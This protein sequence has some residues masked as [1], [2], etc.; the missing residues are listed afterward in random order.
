MS[1]VLSEVVIVERRQVGEFCLQ[2]SSDA[3]FDGDATGKDDKDNSGA[4]RT[5][6]M[7]AA[8]DLQELGGVVTGADQGG[9]G[10][11]VK[12]VEGHARAPGLGHK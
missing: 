4:E 8:E 11:T 2:A 5:V 12:I 9:A 7:D 3:A 10:A 1:I 6:A